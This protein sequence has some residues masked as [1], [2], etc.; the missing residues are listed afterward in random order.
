ME[1]LPC[2]VLTTILKKAGHDVRTTCFLVSKSMYAV[3]SHPAVWDTI[4]ITTPSQSGVEFIRRPGMMLREVWMAP[5]SVA[6]VMW[7]MNAIIPLPH[8]TKLSM[9]PVGD[10]IPASFLAPLT[11]CPRL[12]TLIVS[13]DEGRP[14]YPRLGEMVEVPSLPS[15]KHLT[16]RQ[17]NPTIS[18][19][20]GSHVYENLETVSI[21]VRR[22]DVLNTPLPRL[23]HLHIHSSKETFRHITLAPGG[24]LDTV[25][26]DIHSKVRTSRLVR[27]LQA[28]HHIG[29]LTL[30]CS[31]E[32]EFSVPLPRVHHVRL[33]VSL[34]ATVVDID[35]SALSA[36][37][38]IHQLDIT[39]DEEQMYGL[40][41]ARISEAPC[42]QTGL[43]LIEQKNV[44]FGRSVMVEVCPVL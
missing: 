34:P 32:F 9:V 36:S 39:E 1:H 29:L 42:V 15:L 8:L 43:Q 38:N 23:R 24:S 41:T 28:Q 17:P 11:G 31:A 33:L 4:H 37:W 2:H 40:T 22:C 14:F 5:C 19:R 6:Q 18:Y 27:Q 44:R 13:F 35:Y 21:D 12:E 20:F 7:M 10:P 16:I 26:L 25:E 3:A 30:H